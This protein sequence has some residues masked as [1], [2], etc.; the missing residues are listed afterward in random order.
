[1]R[2]DEEKEVKVDRLMEL[3]RKKAKPIIPEDEEAEED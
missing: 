3:I 2:L 1:M